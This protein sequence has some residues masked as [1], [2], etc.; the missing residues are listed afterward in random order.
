MLL[1]D[2]LLGRSSRWASLFDPNRLTVRASAYRFVRENAEAGVRFLADRITKPGTRPIDDLAPGEGD[3][4]SHDGEKVAA[5]R[6]ESGALTA[7]STTCTHLGCQVNWNRAERSWD[8]PC[9]GSRFAPDGR[10]LQGP[11]VHALERKPLD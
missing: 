11:A 10:V 2:E 4:V 9:H 1:S 6:D 8:C 5:F 7:V 3:I